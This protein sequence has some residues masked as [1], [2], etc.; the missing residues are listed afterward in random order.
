MSENKWC[1][2]P[3]ALCQEYLNT[4]ALDI[5]LDAITCEVKERNIEYS[6]ISAW[7]K[8]KEDI[9][10]KEHGYIKEYHVLFYE[11]PVL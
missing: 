4:Q 5:I 6:V 7:Y 9:K 8:P 3:I 11:I 2:Y 10:F 1:I